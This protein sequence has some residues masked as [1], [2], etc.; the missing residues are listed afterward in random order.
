MKQYVAL[1]HL[2]NSRAFD[3]IRVGERHAI[4]ADLYINRNGLVSLWSQ[5][6]PRLV[7]GYSDAIMSR[8]KISISHYE[9]LSTSV[10]LLIL[11]F[12]L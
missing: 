4:D 12:T 11:P 2:Q 10:S 3:T 8:R 1:A 7:H 9:V 6:Q 5:V